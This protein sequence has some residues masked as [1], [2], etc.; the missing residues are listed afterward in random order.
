MKP[1]ARLLGGVALVFSMA[2]P[3]LASGPSQAVD[4]YLDTVSKV[5]HIDVLANDTTSG[6]PTLRIATGPSNGEAV[7]IA[8]GSPKIKYSSYAT[9]PSVDSFIYEL[10]DESGACSTA[11]VTV[12]YG[13]AVPT[14]TTTG[15]TSTSS[16]TIPTATSP[17]T[18]SAPVT[19]PTTP[20]TDTTAVPATPAAPEPSAGEG[21]VDVPD[22]TTATLLPELSSPLVWATP[23]AAEPKVHLLAETTLGSQDLLTAGTTIGEPR[24]IRLGEDVAYLGR[25]GV[26]TLALVARPALMVSGIVGFLMIGLPQNALGSALGFLAAFRRRKKTVATPE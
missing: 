7:V 14:T 8:N 1:L 18:T 22:P 25:S 21:H 10:C 6:A 4:D 9:G 19:T 24:R 17:T 3:A 20:T 16:T 2:A 15:P 26:D 12:G 23:T 13:P 5:T 11:T